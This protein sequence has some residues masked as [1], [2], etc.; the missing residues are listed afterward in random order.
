VRS[1]KHARSLRPAGLGVEPRR[2]EFGS[3]ADWAASPLRSPLH[4][5][6]GETKPYAGAHQLSRRGTNSFWLDI[7]YA[8]E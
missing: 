2:A 1:T 3:G 8:R 6:A 7:A 5:H 4:L